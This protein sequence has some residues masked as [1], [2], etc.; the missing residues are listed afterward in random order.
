MHWWNA[1]LAAVTGAVE[2]DEYSPVA[3]GLDDVVHEVPQ[4][5]RVRYTQ[6]L[7]ANAQYAGFRTRAVFFLSAC[8]LVVFYGG[9]HE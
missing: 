1:T 2:R 7:P 5:G 3:C 9:S 6:K 8:L 4:W